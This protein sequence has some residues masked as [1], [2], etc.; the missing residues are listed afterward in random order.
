MKITV[1]NKAKEVDSLCPNHEETT[2]VLKKEQQAYLR[3][4][5]LTVIMNGKWKQAETSNF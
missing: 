2:V 5:I 1:R 4:T 3:K